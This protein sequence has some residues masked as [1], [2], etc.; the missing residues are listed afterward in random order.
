MNLLDKI[1]P[2]LTSEDSV[3]RR[4]ALG[5]VSTFPSLKPEWPVR[6][7]NS[8]VEDPKE[9]VFYSNALKN[10]TITS[11][12]VPLLIE[13]MKEGDDSNKFQLKRLVNQL[14][15]EVK[16]EH[17]EGLQSFFSK[18]EWSFFSRLNEATKEE[19]EQMLENHL[20]ELESLKQYNQQLFAQ[21][22]AIAF[23]QAEQGWVDNEELRRIIE[24]QKN[25]PYVNFE[26]MVAVYK[27]GLVKEESLIEE[28][29]PLLL[30]DEDILLE[31]LKNTLAKFQSDRVVQ[32][33]EPLVTGS[34]PIFQLDIIAETHT[35]AAVAA[36]K[37]LYQTVDEIDLQ[38]VIVKGLTEQLSAEGRPEIEDFMTNEFY[39]GIY[40]MEKLAYGYFKV[41]GYDHPELENWRE[42]ALKNIERSR[43]P[44]DE[45]LF[46]KASINTSANKPVV[47]EKIGRNDPCP[48][49][50]GKKYKK[51]H[52]K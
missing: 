9:T 29:A 31:E 22:K 14:P 38:S 45:L 46:D 37:R 18:E 8:S 48:C 5:A 28:I 10:M 23:Q 35:E 44:F 12:I 49:G 4:F 20:T 34:I 39:G 6:L 27:I 52:G 1:D 17:R 16:V 42:K 40:D 2:Y 41:M 7:V 26:G 47:S 43:Q 36:L 3:A 32:A 30:R 21:A 11:E 24:W 50:S 51:C 19:L 15:L 13:A 25:Q 33:V